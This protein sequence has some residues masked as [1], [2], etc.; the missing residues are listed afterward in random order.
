MD[1]V[2]QIV[3]GA[4]VGE[5][6]L[7][8]K[9]GNKAVLLGGIAGTI[10]D[11]DI[12]FSPFM[13]EVDGLAFHRG[14]SHSI[15]FA[16]IG[17]LFFGWCA[18]RFFN[19]KRT[20]ISGYDKS[21]GSL[22]EWQLLFFLGMFTHA[23]LD[24]FTMY[25]TQL[26][27]PFSDYRVAFNSIAVADFFYTIPF[28]FCLIM[29]IVSN[30]ATRR[31]SMW[32]YAGLTIS[33]LYLLFTVVNKSIMTTKFENALAEQNISY[34]RKIVGPTIL[35]NFL[36]NITVDEG[37]AYYAG[38]YSWFDTS[39]IRFRMI[40]K[41]HD[42]IKDA[43]DDRTLGI[44]KWFSKDFYNV[45]TLP[46]GKIQINDLRYG[47][48]DSPDSKSQNQYIFRFILEKQKD[49][50]YEMLSSEGGPPPGQEKQIFADLWARIKGV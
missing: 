34:K 25:G 24:C 50:S 20:Q 45:V 26:F 37:K 9:M 30:K 14:V 5:A 2:T 49:S 41:N 31:R 28:I 8:K 4:A 23:L 48:F 33:S 44:L 38:T 39:P 22:R 36:W 27:A 42:L 21:Q 15:F 47:S 18:F 40:K 11:L 6:V 13:S 46:D 16:V 12:L 3:L 1:S 35:T 32:N 17:S 7:G 19:K 29:A 10:P 43:S